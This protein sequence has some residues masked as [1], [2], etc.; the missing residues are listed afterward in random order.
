MGE[1]D[2]TYNRERYQK[3]PLECKKSAP[4]IAGNV[5]VGRLKLRENGKESK[6]YVESM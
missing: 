4:R 3:V 2:I 1:K 5:A 6:R